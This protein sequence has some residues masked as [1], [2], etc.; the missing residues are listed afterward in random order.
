MATMEKDFQV[1]NWWATIQNA[2]ITVSGSTPD[3]V[4]WADDYTRHRSG[5]LPTYSGTTYGEVDL[6]NHTGNNHPADIYIGRQD[7]HTGRELDQGKW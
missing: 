6:T 3:L 5:E 2:G 4:S 1:E 7:G